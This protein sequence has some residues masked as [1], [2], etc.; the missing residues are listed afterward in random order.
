MQLN[1]EEKQ[2]VKGTD[3]WKELEEEE[4]EQEVIEESEEESEGFS[5]TESDWPS[6]LIVIAQSMLPILCYYMKGFH[7]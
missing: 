2:E 6:S 4:E 7:S 1:V 5:E 3:Q